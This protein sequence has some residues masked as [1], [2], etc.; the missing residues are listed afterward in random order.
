MSLRGESDLGLL[1]TL[2]IAK[3]MLVRNTNFRRILRPNT[4]KNQK[5]AL[6]IPRL[7]TIPEVMHRSRSDSP[8][9]FDIRNI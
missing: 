1:M 2:E 9:H 8:L 5:L 7:F 3:R 6:H 4:L